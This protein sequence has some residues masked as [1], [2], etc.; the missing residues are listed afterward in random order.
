MNSKPNLLNLTLV[1]TL[2]LSGISPAAAS[3]PN[4]NL[5]DLQDRNH[6]LYRAPGNAVVLFFTGMGCPIARK[7][8][9]ELKRLKQAF[10]AEGVTFWIIN[11]YAGETVKEAREEVRELKLRHLPYMLD[12]KQAV[13][14]AFG[15]ETDS[16][17]HRAR[18]CRLGCL[19][20]GGDR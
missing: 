20:Q 12:L 3:V 2:F 19:L 13:S 10:E 8:S 4:F 15:V 6:E 16:G 17:S 5:V 18:Y 14:L 9:L 11:S 7:G 1:L